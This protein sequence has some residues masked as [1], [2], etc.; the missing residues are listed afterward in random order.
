MGLFSGALYLRIYSLDKFGFWSDEL[1]HVISAKSIIDNG[2]PSFPSGFEYK[3]ALAFT[4]LVSLS[5]RLFGINEF[6]ARIPSVLF[7]ILFLVAGFIIVKRWFNVRTA[8]MFFVVMGFSPYIILLSRQS[9]MYTAF[10]LF[11]FIGVYLFWIGFENINKFI[12][13]KYYLNLEKKY[14]IN[15]FYLALSALTLLLSFHFHQFTIIFIP[16]FLIYITVL[17]AL[18]P[19]L[20]TIQKKFSS[21]YGII[22]MGSVFG[23]LIFLFIK[24]DLFSIFFKKATGL[25]A[26]KAGTPIDHKLFLWV[27]R[28]ESPMFFF[29]YPLS[30]IYI[31]NKDFKK[32]IYI[33]S[34]FVVPLILHSF[35]FAYKEERFMIYFFPF[36][37]ISVVILIED[38][39]RFAILNIKNMKININIIDKMIPICLYFSFLIFLFPWFFN[40]RHTPKLNFWIDFKPALSN[41]SAL[42][43]P[44]NHIITL[45][46][47]Q[48]FIFFYLK[49]DPDYYIAP[50]QY[51]K[52]DDAEYK[53]FNSSPIQNQTDIEK[54]VHNDNEIWFIGRKDE[55]LNKNRYF[56]K[57]MMDYIKENFSEV[58][59]TGGGDIL[60]F[61]KN[62]KR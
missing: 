2:H 27:L 52:S 11:Y 44:T 51:D 19:N 24:P 26:W 14:D 49:K 38:V 23:L 37:I 50:I 53:Y 5:F 7:N 32:G 31:I 46:D 39:I 56:R 30:A 22:L 13:R 59:I 40:S 47:D 48:S 1:Y 60:V 55:Y 25:P 28:V 33:V 10:Q 62:R 16:I 17:F 58:K 3:R 42:V 8:I 41:I 35:I 29:L 15:I 34:N 20:N 21:K 12:N 45:L 9:R 4:Y 57:D 18:D 61:K 43:K 36:Y 6:A 54:I